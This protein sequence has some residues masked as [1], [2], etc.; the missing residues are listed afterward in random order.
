MEFVKLHQNGHEMLVNLNTVSEIYLVQG[1][2][3]STLYFNFEVDGEQVR[4]KADE[5]LDEIHTKANGW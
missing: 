5:S 1:S 3:G 4:I 2:E